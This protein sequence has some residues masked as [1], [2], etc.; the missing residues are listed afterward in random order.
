MKNTEKL[1][2]AFRALFGADLIL[3]NP[4]PHI[5]ELQDQITETHR[6]RSASLR[7]VGDEKT[8]RPGRHDG[9]APA[10]SLKRFERETVA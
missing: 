9:I 2:R 1:N 6:L 3:D 10:G 4:P 8:E 5:R 7:R